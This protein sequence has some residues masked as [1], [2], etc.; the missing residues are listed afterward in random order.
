MRAAKGRF[1]EPAAR[2]SN[3][4]TSR[5]VSGSPAITRL[6]RVEKYITPT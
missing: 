5:P 1:P 3:Y 6:D 4:E 2:G